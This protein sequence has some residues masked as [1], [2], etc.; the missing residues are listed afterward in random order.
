MLNR[1]PR[2]IEIDCLE[3]L[4]RD[5]RPQN[6]LDNL[7]DDEDDF[8]KFE[9][10][11]YEE[12]V[13]E[14]HNVQLASEAHQIHRNRLQ[15]A[16]D[17][18]IDPDN[19]LIFADKTANLEEVY[20]ELKAQKDKQES[21]EAQKRQKSKKSQ[22]KGFRKTGVPV[23]KKKPN[24]G[25]RGVQYNKFFSSPASKPSRDPKRPKTRKKSKNPKKL[26]N[27]KKPTKKRKNKQNVHR[28]HLKGGWNTDTRANNF[29][30]PNLKKNELDDRRTRQKITPA[31][32]H[33]KLRTRGQ[34]IDQQLEKRLQKPVVQISEKEQVLR[35]LRQAFKKENLR[36][37]D[38]EVPWFENIEEVRKFMEEKDFN[39]VRKKT[40]NLIQELKI[41]EDRLEDEAWRD[42][43]DGN[44]F[45]AKFE[46]L[47]SLKKQRDWKK[48]FKGGKVVE[49]VYKKDKEYQA[50]LVGKKP[51]KRQ[52][53]PKSQKSRKGS[54]RPTSAKMR[55]V[56]RR[57][58]VARSSRGSKR[59]SSVMRPSVGAKKKVLHV[60]NPWDP[61]HMGEMK[62]AENLTWGQQLDV[63]KATLGGKKYPNGVKKALEAPTRRRSISGSQARR[64]VRFSA[65]S[66]KGARED[67][68]ESGCPPTMDKNAYRLLQYSKNQNQPKS[69]KSPKKGYKSS[70][71]G[72]KLSEFDKIELELHSIRQKLQP[73]LLNFQNNIP[74]RQPHAELMELCAGRLIKVHAERV[75]E[76]LIDDLL[77]ET[78]ENL[79][80][81]EYMQKM[82]KN[83]K[84][85]KRM[86]GQLLGEVN[87]IDV[88]ERHQW[89]NF[90]A[91]KILKIAKN[92]FAE[93]GAK[94]GVPGSGDGLGSALLDYA[95]S[96]NLEGVRRDL[97]NV[98]KGPYRAES[99]L[100]YPAMIQLKITD[101]FVRY[102]TRKAQATRIANE[103]SE[104]GRIRTLEYQ[105]AVELVSEDIMADL[106]KEVMKEVDEV[107]KEF[108]D[109]VINTEFPV[110]NL[111]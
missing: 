16:I 48:N 62:G 65:K 79:N 42:R 71:S 34:R 21:R 9:P 90:E 91:G 39:L 85:I 93:V 73:L 55:S 105:Q 66:V 92:R 111:N 109:E 99:G 17:E 29:F 102:V 2:F 70:K 61:Y 6:G 106:F 56:S 82:D 67:S 52:K 38:S 22:K 7:L 5:P 76:Q 1:A 101:E 45:M 37:G 24:R 50:R 84:Y 14:Y 103:K 57:G 54:L 58:S 28:G 74:S 27:P 25:V 30:D 47:L 81:I 63:M 88:D 26:K 40:R 95:G 3:D 49:P 83:Q 12:E 20:K 64:S 75:I 18:Y 98:K 78:V 60:A 15:E 33:G 96:L 59:R 31:I 86:C 4:A 69:Q 36:T 43:Q 80:K 41:A 107:E 10:I 110:N 53:S 23:P 94:N 13:E 104:K 89:L 72:L 19:P 8:P 87:D 97:R 51:K 77:Y 11:T 108:V 46:G 44:H 35:D 100:D 32:K 68:V